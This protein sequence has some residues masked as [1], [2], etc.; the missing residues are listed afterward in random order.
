MNKNTVPL[1]LFES[2]YP[3]N[4]LWICPPCSPAGLRLESPA[5]PLWSQLSESRLDELIRA[6]EALRTGG[7]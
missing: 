4:C 3:E 5:P 6:S 2:P 7:P 1:I